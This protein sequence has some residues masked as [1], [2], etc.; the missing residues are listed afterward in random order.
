MFPSCSA[1]F[2]ALT[3]GSGSRRGSAMPKL[4]DDI[5][6]EEAP[7]PLPAEPH[8]PARP[9]RPHGWL[10][11]AGAILFVG[12]AISLASALLWRENVRSNERQVFRTN[13]TD[14]TETLEMQL[15]K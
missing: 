14:V 2:A 5:T 7:M 10:L 15:R 6:A 1:S 3:L 8:A 13:A 4:P 12:L 9:S 11:L